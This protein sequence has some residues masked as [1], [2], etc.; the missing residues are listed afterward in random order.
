[1]ERIFTYLLPIP[2]SPGIQNGDL[3]REIS[4]GRSPK[5]DHETHEAHEA[6]EAREA[7]IVSI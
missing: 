4:K 5:G 7:H 6:H 1:M 3:Q 2:A